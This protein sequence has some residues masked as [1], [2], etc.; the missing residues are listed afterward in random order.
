MIAIQPPSKGYGLDVAPA[1]IIDHPSGYLALSARNRRFTVERLP[2]FIA[3]RTQGKHL[4]FLGG[5]HAAQA[6]RGELLDSFIAAA[7]QNGRRLVA[8]QVPEAQA[9]LFHERGFTVNQF[10]STYGLL[11]HDFS[12]AGTKRM[13]LRHKIKRARQA[14]LKVLEVGRELPSDATTFAALQQISDAWLHAK[15]K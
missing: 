9:D 3:Y 4:V 12:F 6:A 2:G 10:G 11:L 5:V 8:V 1:D 13:K 15:R 7:E 14:G